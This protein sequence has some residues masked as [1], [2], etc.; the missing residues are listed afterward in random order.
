MKLQEKSAL[1]TGAGS[2]IGNSMAEAFACEG[3]CLEIADLNFSAAQA[4]AKEI[5]SEGGRAAAIQMDVAN[6]DQ[7]N[8]GLDQV[9]RDFGGIDVLVNNAGIQIINPIVD[10]SFSDL[11][12]LVAT[13]LDGSFLATRAAMRAII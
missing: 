9:V 8:A 11:R 12:K 10:F 2:C 1:I 13:H 4:V 6:E 5:N 3:H 7:V